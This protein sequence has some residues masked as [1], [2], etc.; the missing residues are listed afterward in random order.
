MKE[1]WGRL[2]LR[3][4]L[5]GAFGLLAA[6]AL[7]FLLAII[8]RTLGTTSLGHG[9]ILPTA[10]FALAAFFIGGWF[11]AGWCLTEISRLGARINEK[12]ARPLPADYKGWPRCYGAKRR[13][14]TSSFRSCA[15]LPPMLRTSCARHSL[16]CAPSGKSPCARVM[17][18][19]RHCEHDRQH[20]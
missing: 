2:S 10:I 7:I 4:R 19:P 11:V 13:N 16:R 1:W 5:A 15:V 8:G 3:A 9:K 17:V 6:S 12:P 18:I 20:A 14:A